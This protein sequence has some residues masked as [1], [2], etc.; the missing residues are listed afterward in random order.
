LK[1]ETRWE[2]KQHKTIGPVSQDWSLLPS[3]AEIEEL[4]FFKT[5]HKKRMNMG[6]KPAKWPI[7][8]GFRFKTIQMMEK[9]E[10]DQ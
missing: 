4:P 3:D 7:I 10:Y 9:L 8:S 1:G 2:T 6:C 5:I